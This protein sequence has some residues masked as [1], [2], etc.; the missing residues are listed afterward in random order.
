MNSRLAIRPRLFAGFEELR[1]Q[2]DRVQQIISTTTNTV[3]KPKEGPATAAI[4][5]E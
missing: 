2:P 4:S 1:L 5:L 3:E